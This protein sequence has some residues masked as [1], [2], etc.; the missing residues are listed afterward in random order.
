[1]FRDS[2][3]NLEQFESCSALFCNLPSCT[4][5]LVSKK[6]RTSTT[7]NSAVGGFLT[8]EREVIKL[9]PALKKENSALH[10]IYADVNRKQAKVAKRVTYTSVVEMIVHFWL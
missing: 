4:R 7:N 10:Y 5:L 8:K 6:A 9:R 2:S 3:L 1:M